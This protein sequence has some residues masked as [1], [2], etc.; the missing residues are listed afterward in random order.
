MVGCYGYKYYSYESTGNT[1]MSNKISEKGITVVYSD[2]PTTFDEYAT[3]VLVTSSGQKYESFSVP[4]TLIE[5]GT[6]FPFY[7]N[8]CESFS[9]SLDGS[10][11]PI[12]DNPNANEIGFWGN[13]IT[14]ENGDFGDKYCTIFIEQAASDVITSNGINIVFD[15]ATDVYATK[16]NIKWMNS[17]T[18]IDEATFEP[19]STS[20]FC[21]KRVEGYN[22]LQ[23]KFSS[24]N[25]PFS[26]LKIKSITHGRTIYFFGDSIRNCTIAQSMDIISSELQI[27]TLSLTLQNSSGT[28]LLFQANQYMNVYYDGELKAKTKIY[29]F[30]RTSKYLYELLGENYIGSLENAV[31]EGGLYNNYPVSVLIGDIQ[32]KSDV[33]IEVSEELLAES[34]TGYIPYTTC[35][36]ALQQLAFALQ[37]VVDTSES[38]VVKIYKLSDEATAKEIPSNRIGDEQSI[39]A[40]S[41]VTGVSITAHT[42]AIGERVDE[43]IEE[44]YSEDVDEGRS[45]ILVKFD[46]PCELFSWSGCKITESGVN[47]VIIDTT[48]Y[49]GETCK[50][51]AY[52][53]KDNPIVY[54]KSK[55]MLKGEAQNIS[56]VKDATL[57][58]PSNVES[59]ATSC[60]NY[61]SKNRILSAKI[62]EG[63]HIE[64]NTQAMYGVAKYG[65]VAYGDKIPYRIAGNTKVHLGDKVDV[66]TEYMGDFVGYITRQSYSLNGGQIMKETEIREC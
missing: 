58:N 63:D 37:A 16:V 23:I 65:K 29:Q 41:Q 26:R 43:N 2:N 55:D 12:P 7:A 9:V 14:D 1:V 64:R 52:I 45:N 19:D 53:Y 47:Y 38:E 27:D 5:G 25:A 46:E 10:C 20:Y 59:I 60:F 17:G 49:E 61:L 42:Y 39:S 40:D 28:D 57:V 36:D 66:S 50:I 8:P 62:Y 21:E 31:F 56:A 33:P 15:Q 24:L 30:N 6:D 3:S 35:R 18:T 54:T 48:G 44:V 13:K 11:E 51:Y 22:Q 4:H 32:S 34:V